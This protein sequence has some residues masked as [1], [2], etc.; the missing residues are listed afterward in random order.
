M[1]FLNDEKSDSQDPEAID[2][3]RK[4]VDLLVEQVECADFIVLNKKDKCSSDQIEA[5]KA[6][7]CHINPTAHVLDA[8]WGRVPLDTVLGAPQGENWICKADHEDDLRSAVAAAKAAKKRKIEGEFRDERGHEHNAHAHEPQTGEH[9]SHGSMHAHGHGEGHGEKNG[10]GGHE[11]AHEH[12][13]TNGHGHE[14]GDGDR[15]SETTAASKYGITSFVYSRRRPFHPKRLLE[16]IF[17]LPVKVDPNTGE[18]ADSWELPSSVGSD[19]AMEGDG[20]GGS[21]PSVMRAIIRSKGFAWVANQV[22]CLP[23]FS[24]CVNV[25]CTTPLDLHF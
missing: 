3:D 8:E 22:G 5:L 2:S 18:L 6:I 14:H 12:G 24:P 11:L 16:V 25:S 4:V 7:A 15:P 21:A 23:D 20:Q 19:A 9:G 1:A 17:Q 13:H 10:E